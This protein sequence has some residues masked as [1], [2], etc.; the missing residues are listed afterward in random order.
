MVHFL[1]RG[2]A[3]HLLAIPEPAGQQQWV[4]AERS[5]HD[6]S[7][8]AAAVASGSGSAEPNLQACGAELLTSL[9]PGMAPQALRPLRDRL[10]PLEPKRTRP[11]RAS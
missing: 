4:L 11:S 7:R 3:A 10:R 9:T 1:H 2:I 8:E 5:V 6:R